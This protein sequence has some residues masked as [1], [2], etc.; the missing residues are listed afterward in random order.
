LLVAQRLWAQLRRLQ[1]I[2]PR[3]IASVLFDS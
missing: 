2:S 1:S 3:A